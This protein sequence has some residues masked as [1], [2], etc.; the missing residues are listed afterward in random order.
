MFARIGVM[1]ALN[2]HHVRETQKRA[3]GKAQAQ[4]RPMTVLI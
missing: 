1:Q 2:R 4:E 3:L